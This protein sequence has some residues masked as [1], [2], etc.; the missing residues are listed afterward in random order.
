MFA[1]I[2]VAN[3]AEATFVTE[4]SAH[5]FLFVA[6]WLSAEAQVAFG[7]KAQPDS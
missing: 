7:V 6:C 5:W 4:G 1:V 3:F 2:C